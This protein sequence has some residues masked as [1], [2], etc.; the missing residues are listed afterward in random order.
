[1]GAIYLGNS[2]QESIL[3]SQSFI[4]RNVLAINDRFLGILTGSFASQVY[5]LN[6]N[7]L[8]TKFIKKENEK[9]YK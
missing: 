3:N 7:L 1:M 8:R 9:R 4:K 2:S 6:S 5:Y